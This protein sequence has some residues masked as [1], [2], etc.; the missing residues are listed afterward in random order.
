MSK[1]YPPTTPENINPYEAMDYLRD[2]AQTAGDLK[3]QV[4]IYTE[5]K[6]AV[7]A[8]LMNLAIDAKSEAAKERYADS[9]ED[10]EN[11][12]YKTGEAIG[13]YETLRLLISA[14]EAKLEAWRSLEASARN[15]MRLSQ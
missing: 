10:L 6:R 11:H 3:K 15:E 2:N 7:R 5:M 1:R 9:H 4:Y 12:I 14:H 13:E 8:R